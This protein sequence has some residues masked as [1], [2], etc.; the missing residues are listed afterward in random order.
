MDYYRVSK[1]K[2]NETI[3]EYS[4]WGEGFM[5]RAAETRDVSFHSPQQGVD[6]ILSSVLA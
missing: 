4:G 6:D 3:E 5:V 1:Q 2:T